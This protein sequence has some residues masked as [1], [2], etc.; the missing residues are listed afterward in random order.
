MSRVIVP[1]VRQ[2][3]RSLCIRN[4]EKELA[5]RGAIT[6]SGRPLDEEVFLLEMS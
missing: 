6:T 3:T 1:A 2:T 5:I 4:W